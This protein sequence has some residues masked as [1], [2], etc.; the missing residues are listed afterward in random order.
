MPGE[1]ILLVEDNDNNRML[2]R[3]VLQ[4]LALE[5]SKHRDRHLRPRSSLALGQER[6]EPLALGRCQE[7]G[8]VVHA[9][10]RRGRQN[11]GNGED[12][13]EEQART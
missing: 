6:F 1:L 3:D 11:E 8:V 12:S 13:R 9:A 5:R 7:P 4:A 2:V 10:G